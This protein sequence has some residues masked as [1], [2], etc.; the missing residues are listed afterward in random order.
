MK[1]KNK[2]TRA[3]AKRRKWGFKFEASWVEDEECSNVIKEA[4]ASTG[5]EENLWECNRENEGKK[6]KKKQLQREESV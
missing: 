6:K 3:V 4:W 5:M 2:T 1:E